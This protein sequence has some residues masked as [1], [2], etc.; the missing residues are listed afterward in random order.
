MRIN[1]VL[2]LFI[3]IFGLIVLVIGINV[4]F[5]LLLL[6]AGLSYLLSFKYTLKGFP[7]ILFLLSFLVRLGYILAVDTPPV[8]DFKT[9]FEAGLS[10]AQGDYSFS[11]DRYFSQWAYQTAFVAYEGTVIKLFGEAQALLILKLLNGLFSSATFLFVYLILKN[12]VSEKVSRFFALFGSFFIF[13]LTFVT[14]LSNQQLST[15]LI[16]AGLFFF[17]EK[18][19][20]LRPWVRGFI[21]G[22]LLALGNII[23]PEGMLLIG[24]LTVFFILRLIN[25]RQERRGAIL[26]K[27]AFLFAAYFCL[28]LLVS[29]WIIQAGVN[30]QGLKNNNFLY[31]FVVGLNHDTMGVYSVEDMEAL[32]SRDLSQEERE[33]LEWELIGQR[34]SKGPGKLLALFLSKQQLLWGGNPV[35]W[36]YQHLLEAGKPVGLMGIAIP[37]ELVGE[38]LWRLHNLQI[39][40]L[41]LLSVIG[42]IFLL[43][44][45]MNHYFVIFYLVLLVSAAA[46]L[47]VEIQPRYIYLQEIL[48]ILTSA[49]GLEGVLQRLSP[50]PKS[51]GPVLPLRDTESTNH[52]TLL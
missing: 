52:L 12:Y 47:V 35:V 5:A 3:L 23:R 49:I 48:F 26:S 36:S 51:Q 38:L 7:W 10:F 42:G 16:L 14:V 31:K 9:M 50:K 32:Y 4:P 21:T 33:Q 40:L 46:Y 24:A 18:N 15:F 11:L 19:I 27:A 1:P 17:T 41:I 43:K 34:L 6:A 37:I 8:S 22:L 39:Y 20:T 44:G 13:P 29:Q 45:P 28:N 30:P 25:P 2:F